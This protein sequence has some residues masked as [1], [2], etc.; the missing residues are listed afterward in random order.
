MGRTLL[1]QNSHWK[2]RRR[3][4]LAAFAPTWRGAAVLLLGAGSQG[5][6]FGGLDIRDGRDRPLA[7]RHHAWGT[8]SEGLQGW[9]A[10]PGEA[11]PGQEAGSRE[12][13]GGP[14]QALGRE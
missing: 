7:L 1:L 8:E 5:S 11:A 12:E 13:A 10:V 3:G 9:G 2:R 6:P 14:A 4:E